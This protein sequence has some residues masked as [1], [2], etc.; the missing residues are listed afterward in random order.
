MAHWHDHNPWADRLVYAPSLEAWLDCL[1]K[2]YQRETYEQRAR[3]R[4]VDCY[5]LPQPN[6]QHSMG[7]RHG[8]NGEDYYSPMCDAAKAQEL[9]DK[10]G[11]KPC[12][13]S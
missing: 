12:S 1:D 3:E 6:G 11:G 2:C 4:L 13:A 8:P 7:M 5:I 10:F 9:I